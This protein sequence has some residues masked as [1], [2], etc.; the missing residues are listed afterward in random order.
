M[1]IVSSRIQPHLQELYKDDASRLTNVSKSIDENM[2]VVIKKFEEIRNSVKEKQPA[3]A[4]LLEWIK[5]LERQGFFKNGVNFEKLEPGQKEI[6]RLSLP[7][8]A[9]SDEDL[10]TAE[11][12]IFLKCFFIAPNI[13]CRYRL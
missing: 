3:T 5:T 10:N 13:Y 2:Q 8:L 12:K 6:F 4:E 1:R 7:A 11:N 9:K